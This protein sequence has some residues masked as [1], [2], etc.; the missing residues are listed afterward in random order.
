MTSSLE[1]PLYYQWM[2]G[3]V[4]KRLNLMFFLL[5]GCSN[6][7]AQ[8][9]EEQARELVLISAGK[10][11]LVEFKVLSFS[12]TSSMSAQLRYEISFEESERGRAWNWVQAEVQ[13]ER[14]THQSPWRVTGKRPLAQTIRFVEDIIVEAAN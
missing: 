9:S 13:I 10:I 1:Y 2:I 11:K 12:V 8:M 6:Q 3:D 4:M 14:L 5:V 7:S